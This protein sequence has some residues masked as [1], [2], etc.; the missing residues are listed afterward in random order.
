MPVICWRAPRRWRP[1]WGG[2][3][4]RWRG[5]CALAY[6]MAG[7]LFLATRL[8]VLA[9]RHPGLRIELVMRDQFSDMI[10]ER[11]D[12]ALR[13][14]DIADVSLV[15]RR[16]GY[17]GRA[18]VAAPIYLERHGAPSTPAD[19]ARAR[20]PGARHR[21][22]LRHLAFTGPEGPMSVRVSGGFIANDSQVVNVA[23]RSG[24]GIA[25]LPEFQVIDDLRAGRLFR[26]LEDYPSQLF[27]CT[28][29]IRRVATLPRERG[30]SWTI[31]WN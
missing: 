8:P 7:G 29:S 22:R 10:E 16:V 31:W 5:W 30:W 20:L 24:H 3:A 19:L 18:V 27:R 13:S 28:S 1:R 17:L 15:A 25:L 2:R 26:L 12:L 6:S 4:G 9:A 11:L 23:A 21:A 14:G